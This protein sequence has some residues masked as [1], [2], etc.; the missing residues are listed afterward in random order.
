[1]ALPYCGCFLSLLWRSRLWSLAQ[2][3]FGCI[4]KLTLQE[5]NDDRQDL[6]R[7]YVNAPA[8]SRCEADAGLALVSDFVWHGLVDFD[9]C[10]LDGFVLAQGRTGVHPVPA[11]GHS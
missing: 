6:A 4:T 3:G 9:P 8:R 11:G 7:A 2:A 10:D 1:M 5:G